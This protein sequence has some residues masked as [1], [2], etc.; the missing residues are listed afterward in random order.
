MVGLPRDIANGYAHACEN[1][2]A[3]FTI[4]VSSAW[5]CSGQVPAG[6]FGGD[7]SV[8]LAGGGHTLVR[9]LAVGDSVKVP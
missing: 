5:N 2:D 4:E 8:L 7:S 1:C 3:S 9:H 6:C